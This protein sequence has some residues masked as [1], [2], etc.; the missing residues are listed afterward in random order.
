MPGL[1]GAASASPPHC[2]QLYLLPASFF[3][4][5]FFWTPLLNRQICHRWLGVNCIVT[6]FIFLFLLL[7]PFFK[8]GFAAS[9]AK[10]A[11]CHKQPAEGI[12]ALNKTSEERARIPRRVHET[13]YSVA[14][15]NITEKTKVFTSLSACK[16]R[17]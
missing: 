8:D 4:F 13:G 10:E 2:S 11:D 16:R 5:F 3:S 1:R 9:N 17:V 14:L 12:Q 7:H 6:F 15:R